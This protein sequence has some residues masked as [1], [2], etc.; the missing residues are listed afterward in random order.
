[1]SL[2]DIKIRIRNIT[3]VHIPEKWKGEERAVYANYWGRPISN[4]ELKNMIEEDEEPLFLDVEDGGKFGDGCFLT[5]NS[6]ETKENNKPIMFI[7]ISEDALPNLVE[8]LQ[9]VI[10]MRNVKELE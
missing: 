2:Y 7:R 8:A 4:A 6:Y 1:M 10:R 9:A 5:L 3:K